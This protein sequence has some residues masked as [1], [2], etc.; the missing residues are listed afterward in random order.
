LKT[1]VQACP[2]P[3]SQTLQ[4]GLAILKNTDLRADF[5]VLTVPVLVVLGKKI[6]W[7]LPCSVKN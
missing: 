2:A 3:D 5:A 1:I 7:F 6:A 4:G